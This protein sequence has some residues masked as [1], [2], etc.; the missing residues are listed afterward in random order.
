MIQLSA[1]GTWRSFPDMRVTDE[2]NPG[3]MAATLDHACMRERWER[4]A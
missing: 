2:I 4:A 1:D 3:A